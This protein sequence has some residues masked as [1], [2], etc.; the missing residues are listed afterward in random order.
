MVFI[1]FAFWF[2]VRCMLNEHT[3]TAPVRSSIS[4]AL[5]LIICIFILKIYGQ[6]RHTNTRQIN[7]I[8][9]DDCCFQSD[10]NWELAV[11]VWFEVGYAVAFIR[12]I[13]AIWRLCKH[14]LSALNVKCETKTHHHHNVETIPIVCVRDMLRLNRGCFILSRKML[15]FFSHMNS[16]V[17]FCFFK[18]SP[19]I[20]VGASGAN[21]SFR[22]D[23]AQKTVQISTFFDTEP[24]SKFRMRIF[25]DSY[26]FC[27]IINS[28]AF[29]FLLFNAPKL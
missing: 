28:L 14:K 6:K 9:I 5:P 17:Y 10:Q 1:W 3:A 20:A 13:I 7:I 18:S 22:L 24:V 12:L 15:N 23:A 27:L 19:C 4:Y 25:F 29:L 2:F 26:F 8:I 16:N 11:R 21:L